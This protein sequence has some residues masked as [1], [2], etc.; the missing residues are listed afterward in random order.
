MKNTLLLLLWLLSFSCSSNNIEIS[1]STSLAALK[2]SDSL[3]QWKDFADTIETLF[4]ISL[5]Y[6]PSLKAER[7]QNG[8]GVG[9]QI[10]QLDDAPSNS[11][12]CSIWMEEQMYPIDT[13]VAYEIKASKLK[14]DQKRE[15]ISIANSKALKVTLFNKGDTSQIL[16]Q[17]IYLTKYGTFFE[18]INDRLSAQNFSLLANSIKIEK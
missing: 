13:L 18:I 15:N 14:I 17:I 9:K 7:F 1:Q 6:P 8:I 5:K 11:M 3:L 2:N 12:D 10:K 4:T 16:K